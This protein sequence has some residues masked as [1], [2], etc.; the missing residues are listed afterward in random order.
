[1]TDNI[2]ECSLTKNQAHYGTGKD[3]AKGGPCT[4]PLYHKPAILSLDLCDV[5]RVTA[6]MLPDLALLEIFDYYMDEQHDLPDRLDMFGLYFDEEDVEAWCTLVHVCRKWRNIVFGSPRRLNLRLFFDARTAVK[7]KLDAWPSLPMFV[8]ANDSNM[9]GVDNVIAALEHNDRICR[10]DI[11]EVP[12]FQMTKILAKMQ[13]PFPALT[14]LA[15]QLWPLG[16]QAP[17]VPTSLLGGSAPHLQLLWLDLTGISFPGL[18]NLLLSATHLV[19]LA[20]QNIPDSGYILPE[21]TVTCLSVLTKLEYLMIEFKLNNFYQRLP[22]SRHPYRQT[23]TSLPVLTA[24]DFKG[25]GNYLEDLVARIDAPLLEKVTVDFCLEER[26]GFDIPQV[27]QFFRRT[28]KL[29]AQVD[30][31][32]SQR[33][34]FICTDIRT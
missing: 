18:P 22:R 11:L 17:V 7:K 33:F 27:I 10:L 12:G 4:H 23:R 14:K 15:L 2:P 19:E 29:E 16:E 25:D 20:L 8:C 3:S 31:F 34:Y 32:Q 26:S 30:R 21:E 13:Q 9:W 5:A 1:M 6:D 28:P 24:F